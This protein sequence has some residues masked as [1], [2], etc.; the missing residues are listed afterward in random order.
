MTW[1]AFYLLFVEARLADDKAVARP[2]HHVDRV[3]AHPAFWQ[4]A[5]LEAVLDGVRE[6]DVGPADGAAFRRDV[7]AAAANGMAA[8]RKHRPFVFLAN[9]A[10]L[11]PP[12]RAVDHW[13]LGSR[14]ICGRRR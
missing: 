10:V 1:T 14:L 2:Q 11:K 4:A 9:V 5:V 3:R 12:F 7:A 8:V 6:V 13:A